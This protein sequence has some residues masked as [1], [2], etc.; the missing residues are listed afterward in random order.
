MEIMF[1]GMMNEKRSVIEGTNA[2]N[3]NFRSLILR[4]DTTLYSW[5]FWHFSL[6]SAGLSNI[7]LKLG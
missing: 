5:L 6:L 2:W 3:D 7:D 1:N 4:S